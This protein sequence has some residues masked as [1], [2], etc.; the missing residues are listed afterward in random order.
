MMAPCSF[1]LLIDVMNIL[2]TNKTN[3]PYLAILTSLNYVMVCHPQKSPGRTAGQILLFT[4]Y[5]G[6]L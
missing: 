5:K 4:F 2:L 3:I 6:K 1:H